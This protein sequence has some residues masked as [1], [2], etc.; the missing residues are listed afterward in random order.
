MR[1]DISAARL[2]ALPSGTDGLTAGEASRRRGLHGAND[3]LEVSKPS[4]VDSARAVSRDP[5]IWFLLA[6]SAG[7][8]VLG[9]YAEAITLLVAMLPLAG[10][11]GFLHRRTAAST[12]GLGRQLASQACV[13]RDGI[14]RDVDAGELVPGD[15]VRVQ[16][17]QAFPADGLILGG[18]RLQ[19]DEATLTGEAYPG[20]KCAWDP[21]GT[22]AASD[23][24]LWVDGAHW[25]FAGTRLLTGQAELRVVYTGAQTRY[26][27]IV[28]AAS[29]ARERTP[30]QAA[31]GSLVALLVAAA[32]VLCVMLAAVRLQQGHGW[33]DALVSAAT[34]AVAALPEEFPVVFTAFLGVGVY[35]LARQK[36]LVRRGVSV[37]NIGRVTCIC[38]DKTGTVTEG[39]LKL[40]HRLP[41]AGVSDSELLRWAAL[42]SRRDGGD[43]IDSAVLA[44]PDAAMAPDGEV[45]ATYPYTEQRRRETVVVNVEGRIAA[46]SKGAPEALLALSVLDAAERGAWERRVDQLAA[47][48]HKVLACVCWELGTDWSGGEPDRAARFMGLLA[49][50]DPIRD[51]VA[52]AV[53]ECRDAGVRVVMVTGDHPATAS[54]IARSIG[55]GE[56]VLL[57]EELEGFLDGSRGPLRDLPD[58]V[59][60]ALP[61]EKLALVQALRASGEIVA[62]TGDGVNDVPAL[63]AADVGIAMGERGS[64][65]AREVASIVLLDD[66]FRTM[67]RAIAEGRQLFRNLQHSFQYL[68]LIHIPLV[69]TATYIPLTGHAILYLPV[70]I[71]WLETIIHPTALLAFQ[72]RPEPGRL[73][74]APKRR[75][76]RFFAWRDWLLIAMIGTLLTCL[77][78]WSHERSLQPGGYVEHARAMAMVVLTCASAAATAVLTRLR[79]RAA[80]LV[81]LATLGSTALLVQVPWFA[82]RLSLAPLHG[83]DWL[84]A[85][86]GGLLAVAGPVLLAQEL[87]RWAGILRKLLSLL[88]ERRAGRRARATETRPSLTRYAWFSVLAAVLTMMLKSGAYLLTG[89]VAL[90]SDA[91]E[92]LVNLAGAGFAVIVLAVAARPADET[93]PFGH[94]RAEYFSSGFTGALILVAA[95]G[96]LWT[97][98]DRL[99][100]PHPLVD[101]DLGLL[102]A[103][104]ATVVNFAVARVLLRAGRR[105]DS[106]TLEADGKHLMTD[107]WTTGAVLAGL[108]GVVLTGWNWLDSAIAILAAF[109]IVRAGAQLVVRSLSGLIGSAIPAMERAEVE[110]ILDAY[111]RRG[112]RFHDLRAHVAGSQ[113]L[114]TVHVLVPGAMTVQQGHDLV[115]AIENDLA[116]VLPN[117][118]VV[119]HLEP[120][121]DP[122]SFAHEIVAA[123]GGL[124]SA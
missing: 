86:C 81:V 78:L 26:G 82:Q 71:V 46:V 40:G 29:G 2:N 70:H 35:R 96:I 99:R 12:E 105:H 59:A 114:L 76:A 91:A 11:D 31:I 3:I 83:D 101:L 28:R 123:D 23:G 98:V 54:A 124:D 89:S 43:P 87:A 41:A 36:A 18:E 57:G 103:L 7:Y 58:V 8:A 90:L 97:A 1:R 102:I 104:V 115:Q 21:R 6:T 112:L 24:A 45:L 62:V 85:L 25:G 32:A 88:T 110:R 94:G 111:R 121:D 38:T 42:A 39:R 74:A 64:R 56:Q 77:V 37:E 93:H 55:L 22:V 20:A 49:F 14:A 108:G 34:L 73:L 63:Q 5:M 33:T 16:A 119:T 65:S 30:L 100:H 66:N 80:G 47:D 117:L 15:L 60:R 95:S 68:L 50:E 75:E 17:G 84:I 106:I 116:A 79:T 69:I 52:A 61:T 4:W 9:S 122:A 10:M 120:I 53:K 109:N 107:V 118:L 13:L 92:S 113:R 67:V 48:G 51:G 44:E 72:G 19:A 27:E